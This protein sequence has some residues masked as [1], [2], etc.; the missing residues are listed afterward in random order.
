[1]WPY[2]GRRLDNGEW[3]YGY[4]LVVESRSFIWNGY[5]EASRCGEDSCI[6]LSFYNSL[7]E[8]DPATVGQSTGKRDCKRTAEYPEG[9]EIYKGDKLR[10]DTGEIGIVRFGELPLDKS[11]DCVCRYLTFYVE[12]LGKL[13]QAPFYACV[14]IGDWME[15]IGTIHDKEKEQY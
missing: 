9:Q 5:H 8:V 14:D 3:A 15:V 7:I 6:H 12:C 4:Y 2:R 13:G 1:M 11:G 10:D